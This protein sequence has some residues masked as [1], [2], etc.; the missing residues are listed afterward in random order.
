MAREDVDEEEKCRNIAVISYSGLARRCVDRKAAGAC[1]SPVFAYSFDCPVM[2]AASRFG[3]HNLRHHYSF[4]IVPAQSCRYDYS[5]VAVPQ[6]VAFKLLT[7][8][9]TFIQWSMT[10]HESLSL[11]QAHHAAGSCYPILACLSR[12]WSVM[13]MRVRP[14]IIHRR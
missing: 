14:Q 3:H 4:E 5:R 10:T 2:V 7:L 11:L 1:K 13:R 9:G 6:A 12:C 8:E